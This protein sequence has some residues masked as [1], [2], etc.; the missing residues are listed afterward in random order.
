MR[1]SV[2]GFRNV[3]LG[4]AVSL[5]Y[6]G[7]IGCGEGSDDP[8]QRESGG[9]GTGGA[10]GAAQS[11]GGETNSGGSNSGGSSGAGTDSGPLVDPRAVC[12]DLVD[13]LAAGGT[14]CGFGTAEQ[15]RA[16]LEASFECHLVVGVTDVDTVYDVCIPWYSTASCDELE[17]GFPPDVCTGQLHYQ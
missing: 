3:L 17:F 12:E 4:I 5:P 15:V 14:F 8:A 13:V 2:T 9:S 10:A 7:A 11:T 6:G 1:M 16:D